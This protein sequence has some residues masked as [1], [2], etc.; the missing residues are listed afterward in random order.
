MGAMK[1][2]CV[3]GVDYFDED[4]P[5]EYCWREYGWRG[6]K[7]DIDKE[8]NNGGRDGFRWEVKRMPCV[9]DT[10]ASSWKRDSSGSKL[11]SQNQNEH[12]RK[13]LKTYR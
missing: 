2:G 8:N 11:S 1:N 9:T 10:S 3:C 6:D 5:E 12:L 13:L 7:S 4:H